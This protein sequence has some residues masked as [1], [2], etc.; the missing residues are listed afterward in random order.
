MQI[1]NP[2]MLINDES[3]SPKKPILCT[4][5][6]HIHCRENENVFGVVSCT[7]MNFLFPL[8]PQTK[9]NKKLWYFY[10]FSIFQRKYVKRLQKSCK[11]NGD[12]FMGIFFVSG[13]LLMNLLPISTSDEKKKKIWKLKVLTKRIIRAY[14]IKLTIKWLVSKETFKTRAH[15]FFLF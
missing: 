8:Q 10:G 11:Q 12:T 7:H 14:K 9:N 2:P 3:S 13:N 15:T 1:S 6:P 5:L 4:P